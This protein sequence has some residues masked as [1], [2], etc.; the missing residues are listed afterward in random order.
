MNV[1]TY[2]QPVLD[3][4]NELISVWKRS[5]QKYGWTPVVIDENIAKQ[6][7]EFRRYFE[8]II[9]LPT[10]N[11]LAYE[12][13]CYLR[14]LA[15]VVVGGGLMTDYDVMNYGFTPM[16]LLSAQKA[17]PL[18]F[19]SQHVPCAVAGNEK[20]F[21]TVVDLIQF[22][23][24]GPRDTYQDRAHVSD[25]LIID[26]HKNHPAFG[27]QHTCREPSEADPAWKQ[28]PLVHFSHCSSGCNKVETIARL[29]PIQ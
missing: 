3:N 14:W 28:A 21:Q 2:Y 4:Q 13:A 1:Y 18:T 6:H 20:A 22:Y 8:R 17:K 19:L 11:P 10:V 24:P 23:I 29:R 25:M 27:L 26:A 9:Q 7:P 16:N 12:T 5:W 15:M